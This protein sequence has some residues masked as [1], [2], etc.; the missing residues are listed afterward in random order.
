MAEE[1]PGF[2]AVTASDIDFR[3]KRPGRGGRGG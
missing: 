3:E 1:K 2:G